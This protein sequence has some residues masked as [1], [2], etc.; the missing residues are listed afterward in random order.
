M[1]DLDE[2]SKSFGESEEETDEG[3]RGGKFY[4]EINE[5]PRFGE[6]LFDGEEFRR[7]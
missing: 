2:T 1:D 3:K 5:T 6:F 7:N 4:T